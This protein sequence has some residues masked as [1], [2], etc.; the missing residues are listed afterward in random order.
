MGCAVDSFGQDKLHYNV[1]KDMDALKVWRGIR[2]IGNTGK[3]DIQK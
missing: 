2:N 3:R 1:T